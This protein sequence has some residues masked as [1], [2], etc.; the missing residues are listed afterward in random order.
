MTG[1]QR[2]IF[3]LQLDMAFRPLTRVLR[4]QGRG[5]VSLFATAEGWLEIQPNSETS[6]VQEQIYKNANL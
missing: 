3:D 6:K 1:C 4:E 5:G 2:K